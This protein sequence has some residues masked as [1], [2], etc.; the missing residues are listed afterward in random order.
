MI[1]LARETL[2]ADAGYMMKPCVHVSGNSPE[3]CIL[4]KAKAGNRVG[5]QHN[6]YE[7]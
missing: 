7:H 4:W 2:T 3:E 1:P 6:Y 5:L